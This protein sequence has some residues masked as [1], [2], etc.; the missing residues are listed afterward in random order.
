MR[1]ALSTSGLLQDAR[2]AFRAIRRDPG[3]AVFATLIIGL[4]I[5]ACTAVFSV[6]S[7]L[8]IQPLPFTQP[9][10]LV[11]VENGN[12]EGGM[13]S[14]TSRTSN[15]RDFRELS[16]SFESIGGYNAF[17]DQQSFNLAGAGE[18]ERLQGVDVTSNFLDVLGVE[19][20][21]G[22]N[23]TAE[24]GLDDGPPAMILTH[25]FWVRRFGGDREVVGRTLSLNDVP[26]TVVGVLPPSFDFASIFTPTAA[27]DFLH[28]WPVSDDTDNW[29]NTDITG[30]E[31]ASRHAEFWIH[32]LCDGQI[33]NCSNNNETLCEFPQD[34][35]GTG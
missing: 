21:L 35:A 27:V 19:P 14:I 16:R 7:P 33:I 8:L 12:P 23:F 5:G 31:W 18:P 29:G 17:F 15:L 34:H 13:S 1:E 4:G 20:V 28:P 10:R 22:R 9:E 26:Y 11:L 3:F 30:S 2:Y 25:G 6:M 32:L 24:E